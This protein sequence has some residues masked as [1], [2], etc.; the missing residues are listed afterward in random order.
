MFIFSSYL[1]FYFHLFHFLAH[2]VVL[3]FYMEFLTSSLDLYLLFFFSLCI[4][5]FSRLSSLSVHPLQ[6][7]FDFLYP[8]RA[9]LSINSFL[10]SLFIL[11]Y[12]YFFLCI[13]CVF[14]LS[15]IGF[16][17]YFFISFPSNF[18]FSFSPLFVFFS[19][20]YWSSVPYLLY[21]QWLSSRLLPSPS[22][23]SCSFFILSSSS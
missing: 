10:Y 18:C 22:L 23:T 14:S 3:S 4:Y 8:E 19:L 15:Y 11:Y 21:N 17:L 6:F 9:L 20:R 13:I 16:F 5:V 1:V 7:T 12:I 2:H